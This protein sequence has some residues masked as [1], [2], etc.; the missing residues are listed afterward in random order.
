MTVE[1]GIILVEE[2]DIPEDFV[3][4]PEQSVEFTEICGI[5]S[6]CCYTDCTGGN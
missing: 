6:H 3:R 4:K 2:L 1:E 5:C